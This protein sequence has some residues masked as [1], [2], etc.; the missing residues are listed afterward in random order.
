MIG[1]K[2]NAKAVEFMDKHPK[3]TKLFVSGCAATTMFMPVVASAEG[4]VGSGSGT[5][6][7]IDSITTT[8]VGA[9]KTAYEGAI[10]KVVPVIGTVIAFNV[11]I[12]L[13]RRFVKG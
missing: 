5:T 6:V 10:T 2:F 11:V 7:D 13:V 4:E 1:E 12:R 8:L 3:A 9:A